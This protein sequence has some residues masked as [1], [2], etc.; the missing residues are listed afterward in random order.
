[1]AIFNLLR[2]F[3]I[4]LLTTLGLCWVLTFQNFL[5]PIFNLGLFATGILGISLLGMAAIEDLD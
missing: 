3:V 4:I 1:M 2:L 5:N